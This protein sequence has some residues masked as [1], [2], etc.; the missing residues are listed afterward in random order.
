VPQDEFA[1]EE[2]RLIVALGFLATVIAARPLTAG[3]VVFYVKLD[4][5]I[6]WLLIPPWLAYGLFMWLWFSDDLFKRGR[7]IFHVLGLSA[8]AIQMFAVLLLFGVTALAIYVPPIPLW[9]DPYLIDAY[10]ILVALGIGRAL[11][12]IYVADELDHIVRRSVLARWAESF[13]DFV[14]QGREAVGEGLVHIG[15]SLST[16]MG[17]A[18]EG[19][20]HARRAVRFLILAISAV[21][22]VTA[23]KI[24]NLSGFALASALAWILSATL[25]LIVFSLG[26]IG[27][28]KIR[29]EPTVNIEAGST[30]WLLGN[31]DSNNG[32]GT[33]PKRGLRRF[34]FLALA[35]GVSYAI[36]VF[37]I[38]SVVLT[39]APGSWLRTFRLV[40]LVFNITGAFASLVPRAIR[41]ADDIKAQSEMVIG[42]NPHMR[43][44]LR[45]D[46]KVAQVGIALLAV[47]FFQQLIGN[48][49]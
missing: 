45:R 11:R 43:A 17:R 29:R 18:T 46:T 20:V 8:L 9:L 3:V 12:A 49:G 16:R 2:R 21:V 25:L 37:I 26:V 41:E 48:L 19:P 24:T 36:S 33:A 6:D 42:G 31:Q 34:L 15:R 4:V 30:S 13:S 38:I 28:F 14:V 27:W 10:T 44:S 1:R 32:H 47:G 7:R 40:G 5:F 23:W 39:V 22:G 35:V